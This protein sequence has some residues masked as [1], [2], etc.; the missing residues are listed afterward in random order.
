MAESTLTSRGQTTVPA[1]MRAA[2]HAEPGT[3][4]E[5]HVMPDSDVIVRAKTLSILNLAGS[6]KVDKHVDIEDMN[7]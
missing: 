1:E 3:R 6:V 7:P 5:W 2:L 4:L